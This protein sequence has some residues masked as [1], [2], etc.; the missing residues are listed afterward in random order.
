MKYKMVVLIVHFSLLIMGCSSEETD[1]TITKIYAD[2]SHNIVTCAQIQEDALSSLKFGEQHFEDVY[3]W[4]QDE[5]LLD[6]QNISTQEYDGN[7]RRLD[8]EQNEIIYWAYFQNDILTRIFKNWKF[9]QQIGLEPIGDEIIDCLGVPD[10]YEASY[11]VD[12]HN[13]SFFLTLWYLKKG[14]IVQAYHVVGNNEPVPTI[15]R[16][17]IMTEM[18]T[19]APGDEQQMV[20]NMLLFSSNEAHLERLKNLKPWPGSWS[21][22]KVALD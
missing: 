19:V 5:F 1:E 17:I 18:V 16:N 7:I 20:K 9:G 3:Q 21:N 13:M 15:N 11:G 4:A 14:V 6:E 8:W 22:I 10:F 2:E 12:H